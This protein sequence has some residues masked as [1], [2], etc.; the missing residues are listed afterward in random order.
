MPS[1]LGQPDK[2]IWLENKSGTYSTKSG[3]LTVVNHAI[4]S[5]TRD[6]E[7]SPQWYKNVWNLKVAPKVKM[8]VW[9]ALKGAIP[10]G[11][12]LVERH[13]NIDP[14]CKRCGQPK[15]IIHL[16]FHC[17]HAQKVW[18][19]APF[20]GTYDFRGTIDLRTNWPTICTLPCAPPTGITSGQLSPWILWALWKDKNKL[21]F[22]GH[23]VSPEDSILTAITAA[24]EWTTN[25]S[26]EKDSSPRKNLYM[27]PTSSR[28]Y[29][30]CTH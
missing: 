22:K 7:E 27:P 21:Y 24:R 4:D 13:M 26:N 1:Q 12:R 3:Y 20:T 23:S 9:K 6:Q 19:F 25:Q 16:L 15:S 18:D 17:T 14:R 28:E 2:L 29:G 11:T 30:M 10:V 8:F 5:Q